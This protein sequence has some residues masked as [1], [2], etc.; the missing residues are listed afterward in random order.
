MNTIIES[1]NSRSKPPMD[2]TCYTP[3]MFPRNYP[4]LYNYCLVGAPVN[5]QLFSYYRAG[6]NRPMNL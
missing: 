4:H 5:P 6:N 3:C 1:E 2:Y